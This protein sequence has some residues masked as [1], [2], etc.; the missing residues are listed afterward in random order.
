MVN[1]LTDHKAKSAI[2]NQM[3]HPF[4]CEEQEMVNILTDHTAKSANLARA[5]GKGMGAAL[6]A[7][8]ETC[9]EKVST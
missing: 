9:S 5:R 4:N 7:A 3:I 6:G 2:N 8:R 1:I